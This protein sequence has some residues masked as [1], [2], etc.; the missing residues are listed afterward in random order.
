MLSLMWYFAIISPEISP[1]KPHNIKK[2]KFYFGTF[3][4]Y[5]FMKILIVALLNNN[6]ISNSWQ[7]CC[8][9][10]LELFIVHFHLLYSAIQGHACVWQAVCSDK[11][12]WKT[13]GKHFPCQTRCWICSSAEDGFM[14]LHWKIVREIT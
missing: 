8:I 13:I 4:I 12:W 2:W 1:K 11:H 9:E 14:I 10:I 7:L 3:T 5:N 6:T